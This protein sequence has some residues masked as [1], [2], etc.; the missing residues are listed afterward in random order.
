MADATASSVSP[1]ADAVIA[2]TELHIEATPSLGNDGED[3]VTDSSVTAGDEVS[4]ILR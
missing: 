1:S 4:Y 2:H 3:I